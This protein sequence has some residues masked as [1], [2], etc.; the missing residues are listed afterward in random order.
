MSIAVASPDDPGNEWGG[1]EACAHGRTVSD[2]IGSRYCLDCVGQPRDEEP[3]RDRSPRE[4]WVGAWET[5]RRL[6]G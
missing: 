1:I 6:H 4:E 5:S 3:H 2:R